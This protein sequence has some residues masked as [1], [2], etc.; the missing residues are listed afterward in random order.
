MKIAALG[1]VIVSTLYILLVR[2]LLPFDF[3]SSWIE[4]ALEEQLG[5]GFRVSI[6]S[7]R[8]VHDAAGAPVLRVNR[9]RVRGPD[10]KVLATAPGAEVG[11]DPTSLLMGSFRARRIDLLGAETRVLVG[12]DG[13][14][15]VSTGEIATPLVPG[16][17]GGK[18]ADSPAAKSSAT[19]AR[20]KPRAK[21]VAAPAA[22]EPFHY[23]EL[24]HWL[25]ALEKSGLDGVALA[26]IGLKQGTLVVE[27]VATGRTWIFRNINIHLARPT[28]GGLLFTA[29][30]S[31][32]DKTWNLTATIGATQDGVRPIDI[33]ARNLVPGDIM[34]AAGLGEIDLIAE[35]PLSG[36][37]RAHIADDGRLMAAGLR[38]TAGA[39]TVGSASD[40]EARF[41]VDEAQLQLRFDPARKAILIDPFLMQSGDNRIS[42]AGAIEA[43]KGGESVWPVSIPRGTLTLGTGRDREAPLVLDRVNVR[44]V[45]DP[46]Q[47]KLIIQ[48]GDLVGATTGAAFSGS[49]SFGPDPTLALGIAAS[50]M[51]VTAAKR[52]W[53]A[54]I[55]PGTRGWALERIEQGVI[56]RVLIALNVPLD[57]IGKPDVELPDPA[58]RFEMTASGAA[59]RPTADFPLIRDAQVTAVV[60]GR[61]A[62]VRIAKAVIDT[63]TGRKIAIS[64][65]VLEVPDHLPRNPNGTIRFRFDGPADAIAEMVATE[66]LKGAAGFTVDPAT[67]KGTVSANLRLSLV[68][69]RGLREDELD[70]LVEGDVNGFSADHIVR[71]QRVENVNAKVSVTRA[72]VH[73]KGDGSIAGATAAFEYRGSKTKSEADFRLTTT[74]DDA[75]RTRFGIDLNPWLTGAV[76]VRAHGRITD[77]ETRVDV[78]ADLTAAKVSD[79]VPGWSKPAGRPTKATYRVIER[80]GGIRFEDLSVTGS[81]TTLKGTLELDGDGGLIA[82]NFPVFQLSDGDKATL[83]TERAADGTLKVSVRGDVLDAR[84]LIRGIT[85]GPGNAPGR[86]QRPRDLDLDLH[87]GAA[88]GNNGE[89]IRQIELRLVRRNGEIR[90]F[91]LLGRIGRNSTLVG[92]LRARPGGRPA[93]YVTSGDAG[94]LLRFGDFYTRIQGGEF[95]V[96]IDPPNA[97]GD[98]QEGIVSIREFTIRGEP[99][100]DRLQAAPPPDRGETGGVNRPAPASSIA[101]IRTEITFERSPG[102]FNIREGL[103]FGPTMGATFDGLLDFA[104]NRVGI[105]GTYVPAFGL[106]NILGHFPLVG[107]FLGGPREG[108]I[109]ITFEITGPASGPTLRVNPMSAAAPGFLRKLFEFQRK[110]QDDSPTIPVD[111]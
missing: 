4:R 18:D 15:Q 40:P 75:A 43:P 72:A 60:T 41:A 71:G 1:V 42:L 109:A 70:Y 54:L 74:L 28:E 47:Q 97:A 63:P 66:P 8:L 69:R 13:R 30:S 53:P 64:D 89:V 110:Q 23:P 79:L 82:A 2:G 105:R 100:L 102:K 24:M 93:L 77:R 25:N 50:R 61:T 6:H 95:S 7:T 57:A 96:L 55:A 104:G 106:N 39:G 34:L 37:L 81:G 33:V 91:A 29:S 32:G 26:E 59:F 9:I 99:S 65:G 16:N 27:R 73:A 20:S 80:E 14:V 83:R 31:S 48:K 92:E 84:G 98:P 35:T 52:L 85:D 21:T 5:T 103:I 38:A 46:G 51:P 22:S 111:R 11:L 90:S 101:F 49:I 44:A 76:G 67:A 56:E 78:D 3:A 17:A 58:L 88:A 86:H 36:I 10:G 87:L 94:A 108:L 107:P 19:A 12:A 62:R 45:Y 68:F